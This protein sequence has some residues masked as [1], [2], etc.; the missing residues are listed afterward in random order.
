MIKNLYT[1]LYAD[2][3]KDFG[4]VM[5]Y[6]NEVGIFSVDLNSISLDDTNYEEDDPETFI[7]VRLLVWRI[8]FEK[9]KALKKEL[10]EELMLVTWHLKRWWD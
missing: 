5:F 3:D 1:V 2:D 9:H 4:N 10:S 6:C 7:H 8:I